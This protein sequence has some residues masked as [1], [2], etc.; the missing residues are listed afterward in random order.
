MKQNNDYS[1]IFAGARCY[2]YCKLAN[3]HSTIRWT[4]K[5]GLH[6]TWDFISAV[7]DHLTAY[8]ELWPLDFF[9]RMREFN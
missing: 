2:Y 3:A 9:K 6:N 5:N 4:K 7:A 8:N 1:M